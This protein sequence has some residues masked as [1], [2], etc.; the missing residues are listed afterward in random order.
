MTADSLF[1][2]IKFSYGSR[3]LFAKSEVLS[4]MLSVAISAIRSSAYQKTRTTQLLHS[5]PTRNI[6]LRKL[7]MKKSP[8]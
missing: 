4:L 3:L 2:P 8:Q 5:S 1:V 6:D 7:W